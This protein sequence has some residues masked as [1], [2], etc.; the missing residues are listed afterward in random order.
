MVTSDGSVPIVTAPIRGEPGQCP[1]V[2][3]VGFG[4]G[5]GEPDGD[6][7]RLGALLGRRRR[8]GEV[9]VGVVGVARFTVDVGGE[10]GARAGRVAVQDLGHGQLAEL[11]LVRDGHVHRRRARSDDHL[12]T[13]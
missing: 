2:G 7:Q 6:L 4:H 13:G 8:D 1:P 5:A 9:D 10:G 3:D 11:P 12:L